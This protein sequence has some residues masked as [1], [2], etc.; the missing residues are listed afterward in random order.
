[1]STDA[2][3]NALEGLEMQESAKLCRRLRKRLVFLRSAYNHT[4]DQQ[5]QQQCVD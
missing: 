4:V 2:S 3:L 1:M 5:Q